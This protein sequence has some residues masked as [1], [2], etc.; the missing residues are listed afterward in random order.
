MHITHLQ[1]MDDTILFMEPKLECLINLRR[2]LWCSKIGS[3]LKVNFYKS[4]VSKVSEKETEEVNWDDA[5]RCKKVTL[6]IVYLGLP[7]GRNPN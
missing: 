5:L 6:P 4:C 3:S 7:L 2:I 1:F